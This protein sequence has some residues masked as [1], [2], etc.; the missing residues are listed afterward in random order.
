MFTNKQCNW[1]SIGIIF[2]FLLFIIGIAL[3]ATSTSKAI[4]CCESQSTFKGC[5][6][7]FKNGID[8]DKE[9]NYNQI[10]NKK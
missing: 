10:C 4:N 2:V 3:W 9:N 6:A 1:I 7:Y 5:K 8:M